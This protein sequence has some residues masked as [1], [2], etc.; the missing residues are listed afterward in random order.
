MSEAVTA[1]TPVVGEAGV[2]AGGAPGL[3]LVGDQDAAVCD[4]DFC[5]IPAHHEQTV[6]NRRVDDD[7]V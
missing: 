4:G 7:R 5:E 6:M 3:Q 2:V 1:S